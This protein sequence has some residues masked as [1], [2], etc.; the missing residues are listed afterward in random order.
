[1][2]NATP[3][4][5]ITGVQQDA[6]GDYQLNFS[7]LSADGCDVLTGDG[8]WTNVQ[9]L[10]DECTEFDP[11]GPDCD[12]AVDPATGNVVTATTIP[13]TWTDECAQ[14]DDAKVGIGL[15]S[16][17]AKLEPCSKEGC[18]RVS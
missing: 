15:S 5:L 3:D 13:G 6:A 11:N 7:P 14:G 2:P 17:V 1:M 18:D 4:V 9:T 16:P 10:I 8:Q 12:W